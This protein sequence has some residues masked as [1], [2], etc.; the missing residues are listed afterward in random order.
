MGAVVQRLRVEIDQAE[1]EVIPPLRSQGVGS[2]GDRWAL[3]DAGPLPVTADGNRNVVAA[4]DYATRYAV[5]AVPHHTAQDIAKFI[6]NKLVFV[7]GP[8]REVV[9]DGAPE[10]NGK[11][12]DALVKALQVKQ[13]TPVPYRPAL[14]GLVERFHR[15]WKDMVAMYVTEAQ[16]DWDQWLYCAAYAYNGAKH[17][18]AGY[19]PNEL[20]MGRKLRAPSKL[21]RSNSVTQTRAFAK[22]H[23]KLVAIMAR[24]TEAAH[25]ALAKDQLRR[26]RYYN[27]RVRQDAHFETGD[28]VWVL[29][30]PKGK[31]ITK[32]AHQWVDPAKIVQSAGFDN[33]EV[34]RDDTDE[35]S[36]VHCSFLASSHFPSD[37]L[38]VIAERVIAELELEDGD[39]A[40]LTNDGS[41]DGPPVTPRTEARVT[42]SAGGDGAGEHAPRP[43]RRGDEQVP[44]QVAG[45]NE[46][47]RELATMTGQRAASGATG[48][49][50]EPAPPS[51]ERIGTD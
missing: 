20:M 51:A 22:Y 12:L 47:R 19:S 23:R 32:L 31:G 33:W 17:S 45:G 27:R 36:I 13:L 48:K 9:M 5:A 37:S 7:Y 30:P 42:P 40:K 28:L 3:D 6:A 8:M 43:E 4:V 2:A 41:G 39:G 1:R 21:L 24:A 38:G 18:G 26:E 15:S 50:R 46:Q 35:H 44:T 29:K 14:L 16:D 49:T 34:V 25:A 10:L 11:V